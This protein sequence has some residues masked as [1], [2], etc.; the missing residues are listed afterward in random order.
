MRAGAAILLILVTAAFLSCSDQGGG[1]AGP[2]ARTPLGR[3]IIVGFDG[4]EPTFVKKWMDAGLLPH[5]QRMADGGSLGDLT[6]VL[7]PSSASAWTSAV[8]GVNPGKHGIYGFLKESGPNASLPPVFN[9]SLDRGFRPVWDVLGSYGRKS[10]IVNIPLTSPADSLNGLM[11]AGFPHASD[12]DD[13]YYWPRSLGSILGDYSFDAFRVTCAKNREERFLQ[14]MH[15]ISS[16]RLHLGL[17]LFEEKEWDLYWIV[18]TFPDRFQH[19]MWKYMDPDHPMYD[20]INGPVYADQIKRAYELADSYLGEYMERMREDD[21]LIVM[22][23]HGFGHLYY[24]I[25]ANNFIQRTVG[26]TDNVICG[27]FFGGKFKI[28]VSGPG[29]EERYAS[30][31]RRLIEGL[32]QLK[33]P[34]DG[35]AIVDSIYL[36]DEIWTGPY[37]S[38]APDIYCMEKPGFLFFTLPKTPDLRL[39]DSG[40]S[41]DKAFSGF[42]R[43]DGTLG[44]Y[45][46]YVRPGQEV[47][48]RIVD[49]PA[50]I[51]AYLGVPAP[52]ELDGK[53][54]DRAFL[55]EASEGIRLVKGPDPGYIKP[56]GLSGQDSEKIENQ[57][58]SVGYIQ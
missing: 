7:P 29:A 10:C 57:L 50:M 13:S 34:L 12:D 46:R 42:H 23:D 52:A 38:Q 19:Y 31:K 49:I 15:S 58:R 8:T 4:L 17:R 25:N 53:I 33:S 6:T 44:L 27:D 2:E 35:T 16:K 36:K 41:P 18:Y 32:R 11:I 56:V 37:L 40:P 20:P 45:G 54:P 28:E 14:K 47:D 9:T 39:L 43:R 55:E 21:L 48:G 22:S 5:F 30:I 51:M 24:T 1:K 3:V 26:S